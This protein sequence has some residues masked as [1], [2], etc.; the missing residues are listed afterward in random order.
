MHPQNGGMGAATATGLGF[1]VTVVDMLCE[2]DPVVPRTVN[3]VVVA[4]ETVWEASVESAK[5]Y[6]GLA[7]HA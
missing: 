2:H 4:G 6:G 7:V 3:V 1:T 5:A